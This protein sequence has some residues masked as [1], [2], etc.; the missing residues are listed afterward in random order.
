MK[1]NGLDGKEYSLNLGGYSHQNES[2]S[3]YHKIA[4][5]LLHTISPL[6]TILEE[7]PLLGAHKETLYVDFFLPQI[8]LMIE[9]QGEQHYSFSP[10]FHKNKKMFLN[11][12][13]RDQ[14][15]RDWCDLNEITL[16]ELSYKEDLS[17]WRRKILNRETESH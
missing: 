11:S 17:E 9:V 2:C 5:N 14:C 16:V 6:L 1:V 4:R 3:S 8:R 12:L 15:K 13:K 10:M 7:V